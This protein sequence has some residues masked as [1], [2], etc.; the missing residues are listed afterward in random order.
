MES[1]PLQDGRLIIKI[2]DLDSKIS[3]V[4]GWL[5]TTLSSIS[6]VGLF[7]AALVGLIGGFFGLVGK[8]IYY[9]LKRKLK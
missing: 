8:E 7:Q 9:Y 5:L 4:G 3:F 2:M 6:I 1:I